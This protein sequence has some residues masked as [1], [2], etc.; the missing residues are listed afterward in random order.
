MHFLLLTRSSSGFRIRWCLGAGGLSRL[1]RTPW[2]QF[3]AQDL[4]GQL[5]NTG[6]RLPALPAHRAMRFCRMKASVLLQ[7]SEPGPPL[8]LLSA[9]T[10]VFFSVVVTCIGAEETQLVSVSV[11]ESS[12]R[13]GNQRSSCDCGAKAEAEA[14]ASSTTVRL[15]VT[16]GMSTW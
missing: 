6:L 11:S 4:P 14:P 2:L 8:F 3:P 9:T 10:G 1:Q 13:Q 16:V 12:V 15:T 7:R 5:A